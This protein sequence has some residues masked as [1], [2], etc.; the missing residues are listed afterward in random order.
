MEYLISYKK[1]HLYGNYNQPALQKTIFKVL[2]LLKP[3]VFIKSL[4][5][6]GQTQGHRKWSSKHNQALIAGMD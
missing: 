2:Y 5:D 3:W 1:L 6:F 4:E